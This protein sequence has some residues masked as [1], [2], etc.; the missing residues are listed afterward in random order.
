MSLGSWEAA[1]RSE[2]DQAQTVVRTLKA[3]FAAAYPWFAR[4]SAGPQHS[5]DADA[6][7][8]RAAEE[9]HT[10]EY[11]QAGTEIDGVRL[12]VVECCGSA[13]D[14]IVWHPAMVHASAAGGA[15]LI[16]SNQQFFGESTWK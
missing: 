16:Y 9:E 15:N 3:K 5:A 12:R 13:G 14:A 1:L 11:M 10:R 4:L 6:D 8:V 7:A 2:V